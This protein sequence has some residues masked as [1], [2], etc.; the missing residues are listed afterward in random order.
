MC[1]TNPY[2]LLLI[3]AVDDVRKIIQLGLEL[4]VEWRIFTAQSVDSGLA[5]LGNTPIDL[6][7]VDVYVESAE[8]LAEVQRHPIAQ[9][10]PVVAIVARDRL[11]D[12]QRHRQ[13]GATAVIAKPFDPTTLAQIIHEIIQVENRQ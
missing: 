7:L 4:T 10:I 13:Q 5:I 1:E 2:Q 6:I 11:N 3:E 9:T 12:Q 8:V